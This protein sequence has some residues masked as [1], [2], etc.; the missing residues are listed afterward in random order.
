MLLRGIRLCWGLWDLWRWAD[1]RSP[2]SLPRPSRAAADA[3]QE[4]TAVSGPPGWSWRAVKDPQVISPPS[5]GRQSCHHPQPRIFRKPAPAGTGHR[6]LLGE[7]ELRGRCLLCPSPT[8]LQDGCLGATGP[9]LTRI[10][11]GKKCEHRMGERAE[12]KICCKSLHRC[13]QREGNWGS[14]EGAELGSPHVPAPRHAARDAVPAPTLE[15]PSLP[16]LA[17]SLIV[18]IKIPFSHPF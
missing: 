12:G 4:S 14:G 18:S 6:G 17:V 7:P 9:P 16:H 15:L 1:G 3:F 2:A 13:Q 5:P 11:F 8:S 10:Y